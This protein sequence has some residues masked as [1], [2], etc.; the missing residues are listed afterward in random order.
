[1]LTDLTHNDIVYI[2]ANMRDRDAQ[3]IYGLRDYDNADMLA[4]EVFS[5]ITN[6]GR[7]KISWHK[8]RPAAIAAFV[9][10]YPGVWSVF[11]FGTADFKAGAMPLL[12]WFRKEANIILSDV[13]GHRLHCD[14]RADYAEAHKMIEAM[15]G[16]REGPPMRKFGKDGSSYQRFVWLNGENDQVLK[17]GYVRAA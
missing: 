12:R 14:S 2:C 4:M 13:N 1:M 17:S 15:G 9:E 10:E 3:E 7:G 16:V 6:R 11:M 5:V 8:G